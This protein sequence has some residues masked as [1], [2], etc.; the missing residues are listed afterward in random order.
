MSVPAGTMHSVKITSERE[1]SYKIHGGALW[2]CLWMNPD[3]WNHTDPKWRRGNFNPADFFFGRYKYS[4]RILETVNVLIP[5]PEK[6]YPATIE[7]REDSWKRPRWP[8]TRYMKRANIDVPNGIP[9]QGKGEN[10]WD[11]GP[12][13]TYGMTCPARTIAQAV[14]TMV[15]SCYRDRLRYGIVEPAHSV[16]AESE[17]AG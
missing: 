6:P 5:M 14:G 16:K 13:A 3:E 11:C 15:E 8:F 4:E 10:S 2:W 7:M 9:H 12:D 1:F 17:S